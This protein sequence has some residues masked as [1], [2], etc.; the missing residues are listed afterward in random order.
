MTPSSQ[1]SKNSKEILNREANYSLPKN[2]EVIPGT[3]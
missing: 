2:S 3:I 1:G